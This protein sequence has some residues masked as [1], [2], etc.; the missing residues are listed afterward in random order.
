MNKAFDQKWLIAI[1]PGILALTVGVFIVALFLIK[2]LWGW[3]I[4]DLFPGAVDQGL[5]ARQISWYTSLKLAIFIA[6]LA[7]I[8]GIRGRD[9]HKS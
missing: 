9:K 7:G 2:F 8:T 5:I 1:V 3:T 4:P 6:V